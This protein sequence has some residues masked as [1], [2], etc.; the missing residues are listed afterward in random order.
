MRPM[1]LPALLVA[2]LLFFLQTRSGLDSPLLALAVVTCFAYVTLAGGRLLGAAAGEP[3]ASAP[4]AWTLGLLATCLAIYLL[5]ALLPVTAGGAFAL[6][7]VVVAGLRVAFRRK[8][9]ASH[10]HGLAGFALCV[11]FTAAWCSGPASAYATLR[12]EDVLPIWS[13]YYFHGGIISQFGDPRA[14]GRGSIY[15][16]DHP[17]SFY[18]FASYGAAAA[19]ARMLDQP[20][21]ALATS[22]WL[23]LGFLAMLAGA[24]ALGERLAG[25]AGGIAALA[26][27]AI[28]PD[29]SN[30]GLRNGWF[31]F[32]WNLVAH[33]GATYALGAAFASFALLERWS[34]GRSRAALIASGALA[35]SALFF[36]FHVFALLAPAWVAAAAACSVADPARRR[37]LAWLMIALLGTGAAGLSLA[38]ARLGHWR[39]GEP[40]LAHFLVF[41]HTAHEPTAYTGVYAALQ[42]YDNDVLTLFAGIGLTVL[43]ALGAFVV[44]LPLV[45][46][47]AREKN[48][49]RPIDAACAYLAFCWVLLLLFAPT[50]W[51]GDPSDLIHRPLV[52]LYA[53]VALWTLCLAVRLLR[54]PLWPA[55]AAAALLALPAIVVSAQ[56]MI[57]PKFAWGA[58]DAAARVPPGLVETAAYLR[59]HGAPGDIFAV[60]GLTAAYATFDLPMQLCALSGMPSYLTRPYFESLKDAPRRKLVAERLAAL[61]AIEKMDDAAQAMQALR[62]L[63]VQWYVVAR[64]HGARWDPARSGA[65]LRAG[66]IALYRIP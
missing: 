41:V 40:A 53:A 33:G 27:L 19:L 39:L 60:A 45:A 17:S 23:P 7:A 11:A 10:W 3:G 64:E 8:L 29:T 14:L 55:L 43:A 37:K 34:T 66:T 18:H 24:Y 4:L 5:T 1:A 22:A 49:L 63:G 46:L 61:Q 62:A 12:A 54:R 57:R 6:I 9:R 50:P 25:A 28:L 13:D 38:L 48:L 52:L 44:L 58:Q 36:R 31:S 20:G 51:H 21:V 2:A 47:V 16:A 35:A 42:S 56:T 65:T 26:A 59:R 32:H 15:L 30:Y